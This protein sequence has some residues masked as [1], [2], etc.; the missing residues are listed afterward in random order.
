MTAAATPK[1]FRARYMTV[2]GLSVTI[3]ERAG[4]YDSYGPDQTVATCAGCGAEETV[5]WGREH[6]GAPTRILIEDGEHALGIARAW[7]QTHAEGCRVTHADLAQG[8]L[9]YHPADAWHPDRQQAQAV[10]AQ[11]S[12][13]HALVAIREELAQTRQ[14][15]QV[16]ATALTAELAAIRAEMAGLTAALSAAAPIGE[17]VTGSLAAIATGLDVLAKGR[18]DIASVGLAVEGLV[19]EMASLRSERPR[20][21]WWDRRPAAP[22]AISGAEVAQ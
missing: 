4:R 6:W 16:Q 13:A 18:G 22:V 20:R 17:A 7:A 11:L 5:W 19:T 10:D 21:P 12:T 9:A 3:A 2:G 1:G 14:A 15:H 8:Y